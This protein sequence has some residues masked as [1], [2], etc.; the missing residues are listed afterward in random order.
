MMGLQD[1]LI[2]F[3]DD[4]DN[5][6]K[7][8][9]FFNSEYFPDGLNKTMPHQSLAAAIAYTESIVTLNYSDWIREDGFPGSQVHIQYIPTVVP[10][11]YPYNPILAQIS[12]TN[13]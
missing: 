3:D 9:I 10:T 1:Y 6:P 8:D 2:R 4:V 7:L 11:G 5:E 13:Y 12:S